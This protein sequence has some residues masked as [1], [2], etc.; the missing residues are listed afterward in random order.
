MMSLIWA[1]QASRISER[2]QMVDGI[3]STPR[4]TTNPLTRLRLGWSN[5]LALSKKTVDS[6]EK[7]DT[8]LHMNTNNIRITDYE[9]D[10]NALVITNAFNITL[11]RELT[12]TELCAL[13]RNV[14]FMED[15][16]E[17]LVAAHNYYL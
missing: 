17:K 1:P 10:D 16:A 3:T 14:Q 4:P 11:N 8:F 5:M 7:P 2:S 6:S 9:I 13:N 15:F 12:W